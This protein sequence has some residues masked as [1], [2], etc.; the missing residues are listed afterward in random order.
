[1]N[2]NDMVKV[3]LTDVGKA[4]WRG[5]HGVTRTELEMPLWELMSAFGGSSMHMGMRNMY[6]VNNEIELC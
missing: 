1:M 5:L 6:F 3:K 4:R 2:I